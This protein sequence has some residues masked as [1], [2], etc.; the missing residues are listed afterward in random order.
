MYLLD[1]LA[2]PLSPAPMSGQAPG[3]PLPPPTD[4]VPRSLNERESQL[5]K[6][7]SRLQFV[8]GHPA[9]LNLELISQFLATAP[10][11][12]M[13]DDPTVRRLFPWYCSAYA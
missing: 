12:W 2:D 11:R 6:H 13:A 10:T 4:V 5:V 8:R 3:T 7:L 9:V 1:A